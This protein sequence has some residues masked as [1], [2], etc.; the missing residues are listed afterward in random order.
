M[1]RSRALAAFVSGVLFTALVAVAP[2]VAEV[3][4]AE[5][6]AAG[7]T[8]D[9]F[10]ALEPR[11]VLD[12]RTGL[13]G[14]TGAVGPGQAIV[15]DLSSSA[16]PAST[17]AVVLNVTV[18]S[19]TRE[20]YVTVYPDGQARPT[21]SN[22]N[23]AAGDIRSNQVTV[24]VS[25]EGRIAL[26][27]NTGNAHLVADLSGRYER[28]LAGRFTALT[29][30]RVMD[31]YS[32]GPRG[33]TVLDLTGRVPASASA[34]TFNLTAIRPTSDTFVTAWPAGATQPTSSSLN[35]GAGDIRPNLVTVP[36][37]GNRKV[38]LYNHNGTVDVTVDLAGFY[39]A[40]SGSYFLP[41]TPTRVLDTRTSGGTLGAG[42]TRA[43][44]ATTPD[45]ATA[46]VLNVTGVQP[47]TATW[48]GA[49]TPLSGDQPVPVVSSLNLSAGEIAANLAVVELRPGANPLVYNNSGLTNVVADL[50]GVFVAP[51]PS[52]ATG[53]AY[54][55][56]A[57]E[58]WQLGSGLRYYPGPRRVVDL[59]GVV[60]QASAIDD[61]SRYAL[62]ANG[63]VV[64]WGDNRAG[65]LG[66]GWTGGMSPTPVV[67]TGLTDVT[68][69]ATTHGTAVA[70]RS[71]GTVWAWGSSAAAGQPSSVPVRVGAL[72]GVTAIA[73]GWSTVYL[74]HSDG[75]V[76]EWGHRNNN[77]AWTPVQ[78]AG[79]T[80]VVSVA[81]PH[82]RGIAARADG[83]V[84]TWPHDGT[85][86]QIPTL[87]DI[88]EVAAGDLTGYAL[89]TDGTV[90]A[91]GDG[92]WGQL[93]NGVDC[94]AGNPPGCYV[95]TPVQV[96]GLTDVVALPTGY[97]RLNGYALRADG[98]AWSWGEWEHLGTPASR[99]MSTPV[100]VDLPSGVTSLSAAGAVVG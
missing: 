85:P 6:A 79:L 65:Q 7:E 99:D 69:I 21:V 92:H 25:G 13:G 20:T 32:V 35:I 88:T 95:D 44:P 27:N 22:L 71:D 93:G 19:P 74:L 50:S 14:R 46:M 90:W 23:V 29:P 12:T 40:A 59:S 52:C 42:T 89:R 70:L 67:V 18:V 100:R 60:A 58:R 64:A 61:L 73:A 10:V 80:D 75:T 68:A 96:V 97:L 62:L 72:S 26:Y 98:T 54:T 48:L 39:S 82:G 55:W 36:V 57:N 47:T 5:R 16:I 33:T 84:W 38:N 41:V 45:N 86:T 24:A 1:S 91:W 11:R 3:A 63:T 94:S 66:G 76:W 53:C 78:V 4:P 37:G 9:S 8:G 34:V 81:A 56:G 17:T 28:T 49:W 15:V 77:N 2:S 51:T 87:T 30:R 83:T 43:I 31:G